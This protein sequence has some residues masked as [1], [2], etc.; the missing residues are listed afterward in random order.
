MLGILKNASIHS[1][2]RSG[3][4][5][6]VIHAPD[7]PDPVG[8]V[9][10]MRQS[11]PTK[12]HRVLR[13][14]TSSALSR[15][16]LNHPGMEPGPGSLPANWNTYFFSVSSQGRSPGTQRLRS[17]TS[18]RNSSG[19]MGCRTPPGTRVLTTVPEPE[20]NRSMVNRPASR[21]ARTRPVI[22]SELASSSAVKSAYRELVPHL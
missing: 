13:V 7:P 21:S 4:V 6:A 18:G 15:L 3:C 17:V 14:R 16:V 9:E 5:I 11:F 22:L 10:T 1:S 20:R 12:S 8:G 2:P 19:S